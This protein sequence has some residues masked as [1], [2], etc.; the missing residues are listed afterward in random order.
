M[1]SFLSSISTRL[2]IPVLLQGLLLLI[3]GYF[4][5]TSE[6][7]I[8]AERAHTQKLGKVVSQLQAIAVDIGIFL[9]GRGDYKKLDAALNEQIA[10]IDTLPGDIKGALSANIK[11]VVQVLRA[12]DKLFQRN[13]ELEKELLQLTTLAIG[14]SDNYI[15]VMSGKLADPSKERS[16]SRLERLV[17]GG[18][19]VNSGSNHSIRFN[20]MQMKENPAK[21]SEMLGFLDKGIANVTEDEK[22]LA[23][24]PFVALATKSKLTILRIREI[25]TEYLANND[26]IMASTGDIDKL[27]GQMRQELDQ[28]T[29]KS[30]V[31][32]FD[33]FR[34]RIVTL[35]V[36]VLIIALVVATVMLM[37]SRS[38]I[39]PINSMTN[40]LK[41]IADGEGDLTKRLPEDRTDE[42]GAACR[43]F[44]IFIDKLHGIIGKVART[45]VQVA[46]DSAQ[47]HATAK[48]MYS[49]VEDVSIQVGT[50]ATAGEE[51][52]ATSSEITRNCQYAAEG[53]QKATAAA[54]SGARVVDET[55]AVM[56]SISDR[57]KKSAQAVEHLGSRS[58]QI[59]QIVG[60]IEDIA[61]Q[62]NLLALNAAIEA[63]RAGEQ[64]RGFAV[65]ADEVRALA[66]RTTRA[67]KEIGEMIRMIQQETKGAVVTMEEGVTEVALG[68]EKAAGSGRALDNIL[69]QINAVTT[70]IHQIASAAE[71]QTATTSEISSNMLQITRVM[72][73]TAKGSQETSVAADQLSRHAD[74]LRQIV[75]QFKLT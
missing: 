18:A 55:I 50:V 38:I 28:L 22:H 10:N 43:Q 20:F 35:L 65:V 1:S 74:E 23:G 15:T 9:H 29:E 7:S 37:L 72:G 4:F 64:G 59:G 44:N 17:I 48:Q 56:T 73:Q 63:A 66:E 57:V 54:V 60:T 11:Q 34:S 16:V 40:V 39:M 25:V 30:M 33:F 2:K 68:S 31:A 58:D 8:R 71:E 47:L 45:T 6:Y 24:T 19:A 14:I 32:G 27:N 51:M 12:A 21:R 13:Q 67:T 61:D 69:E 70:Q 26:K 36:V 41:D 3:L 52:S 46:T 42:I 5:V 49:G 62:T 75:G 53:S